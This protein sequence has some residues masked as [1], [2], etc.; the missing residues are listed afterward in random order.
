MATN[1]DLQKELK[2]AEG[3]I[4]MYRDFVARKD[5]RIALGD[6]QIDEETTRRWLAQDQAAL[7][8]WEA[9]AQS[10]RGKMAVVP[11]LA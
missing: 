2:S 7:K 9:A 11:P 10:I 6:H 1:P 8:S 3:H 5:E 4:Q